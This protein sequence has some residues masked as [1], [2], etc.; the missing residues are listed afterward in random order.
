MM[1]D[2]GGVPGPKLLYGFDV[3]QSLNVFA[4]ELNLTPVV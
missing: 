3:V 4:P 2:I 1:M